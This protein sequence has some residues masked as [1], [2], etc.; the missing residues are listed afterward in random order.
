MSKLLSPDLSS[1]NPAL[2]NFKAGLSACL[3]GHVSCANKDY[4]SSLILTI[5]EVC[6]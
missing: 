2:W 6:F 3:L 5:S 1:C 4:F